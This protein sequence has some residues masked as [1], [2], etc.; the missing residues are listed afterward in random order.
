MLSNLVNVE[1]G[2]NSTKRLSNGNT[3]PMLQ[4]P[5]GMQAIS[6]ENNKEAESWFYSP[7]LQLVEGFRVTQQ[8]SPW[9]KDYGYISFLP[10]DKNFSGKVGDMWCAYDY[11]EL[12]P[13]Q[14]EYNFPELSSNVK[15][16]A[17]KSGFSI[18]FNNDNELSVSFNIRKSKWYLRS[19]NELCIENNEIE[20][21]DSSAYGKFSKYYYLKFSEA[22]CSINDYDDII[23]LNF[24]TGTVEMNLYSSFISNEQAI[25]NYEKSACK[26]YDDTKIKCIAEWEKKLEVF[27]FSDKRE[28]KEI[29]YSNLYRS[30][31]YPFNIT[32]KNKNDE[33]VYF[34][35]DKNE[36]K[37]GS[38]ITGIGFWDTYR[39][40]FPLYRNFYPKEYNIFIKSMLNFYEDTGWLPRW[41]SP[42]EVGC[43]PSTMC[44]IVISEALCYG[45]IEKNDIGTAVEAL[46]KNC[47]EFSGSN[48]QGR[49][50]L[51]EYLEF[52]YIPFE[53]CNHSVTSTL[54]YAYCD[55]AVSKAIELYDKESSEI[56]YKR[57]KN[58]LNLWNH[59]K[60]MFVGKDVMGNFR[61]S[62]SEI[63]WGYDYCESCSYQNNFNVP[64]D[65]DNIIELFENKIEN[66]M[67]EL[68]NHK[69][70]YNVG[71][72]NE[73]IHEQAELAIGGLGQLAISNQPSFNIP[74]IY[75]IINK[76]EEFEELL[77]NI[78][79]KFDASINGYPG[80]EDNGSMSS[81]YIWCMLGMYPFE[82]ASGKYIFFEPG[83]DEIE[84]KINGEYVFVHE[85]KELVDFSG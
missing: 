67:E 23:T 64:F 80:D 5:F 84:V 58:Y 37:S 69:P 8:P 68:I 36:V 85:L 77:V 6:V 55:F 24:L 11:K 51:K 60:M 7:N 54:D 13:Y 1:I 20:N 27:K 62:F 2:T 75:Q 50:S 53:S 71:L 4:V 72:Y 83:A 57:S 10:T 28:N 32:E 12:H 47:F 22:V 34:S 79:S 82:P 63:D 66:R 25:V 61:S 48:L 38:M 39:T 44:D 52:G 76:Q 45:T 59:S 42:N 18:V 14:F 56:L 41:M 21:Q 65:I 26:S 17:S 33:D 81:W 40:S 16:T 19:A 30:L 43:M 78:L 35:F 9:I 29:F 46:K 3:L 15:L 74:F 49:S 70:N 31:L 73:Q